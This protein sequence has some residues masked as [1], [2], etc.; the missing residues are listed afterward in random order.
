MSNIHDAH[1]LERVVSGYLE[2]ILDERDQI[3]NRLPPDKLLGV[4]EA[5]EC[6]V[7]VD[8]TMA[9]TAAR[10]GLRVSSLATIFSLLFPVL[11][12]AAIAV[13]FF[14][15]LQAS[16]LSILGSILPSRLGGTSSWKMFVMQHC[17]TKSFWLCS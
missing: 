10:S 11:I 13:F 4:F 3:L 7:I 5:G 1:D 17:K 2:N 8:R 6:K 15:G 14:W 16:A 12:V 9:L